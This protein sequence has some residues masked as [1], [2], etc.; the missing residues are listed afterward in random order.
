MSI[1]SQNANE[2]N[3]ST[4]LGTTDAPLRG[5]PDGLS[6][7]CNGGNPD[8]TLDGVFLGALNGTSLGLDVGPSDCLGNRSVDGTRL[9]TTDGP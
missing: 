3:H 6:D 8:G 1:A 2:V 9:G 4:S 7:G 5:C